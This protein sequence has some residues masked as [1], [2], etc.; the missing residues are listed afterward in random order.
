MQTKDKVKSR[1]LVDVVVRDGTAVLELLAGED[2]MVLI[3]GNTRPVLGLRLHIVDRVGR[4]DLQRVR[5]KGT[6]TKIFFP[7]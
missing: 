5:R 3:R 4:F 2:E 7:R 1:L 6:T